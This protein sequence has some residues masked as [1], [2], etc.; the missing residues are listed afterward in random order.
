MHYI[1]GLSP[2]STI[3]TFSRLIYNHICNVKNV[4]IFLLHLIWDPLIGL[5]CFIRSTIIS[6]M[7]YK[8]I[9]LKAEDINYVSQSGSL[10]SSVSYKE[11]EANT[12][13]DIVNLFREHFSNSLQTSVFPDKWKTSYG[14]PIFKKGYR[15]NV[16]NYRPISKISILPKLFSKLVNKKLFPLCEKI[17]CNEQHGFRPKRSSVTNL[18][19]SKQT[20]LNAFN[21]KAQK[22]SVLSGLPQGDHLLPLLIYFFIND[23]VKIL[24]TFRSQIEYATLIWRHTNNI[25]QNTSLSSIQN[26]IKYNILYIKFKILIQ[27]IA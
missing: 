11:K 23:I 12:G 9:S 15:S 19:I 25:G 10:P 26:H 20:I 21:N 24:T 2:T 6:I 18:C 17:I 8:I 27:I 5:P 16:S 14:T 7:Q 3:V 13:S 1:L 4:I 22:Q